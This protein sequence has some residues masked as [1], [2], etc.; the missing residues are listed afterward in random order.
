MHRLSTNLR[1]SYC[2]E[3][4]SCGPVTVSSSMSCSISLKNRPLHCHECCCMLCLRPSPTVLW[5]L[6]IRSQLSL[7]PSTAHKTYLLTPRGWPDPLTCFI[8]HRTTHQTAYPLTYHRRPGRRL[9]TR[10]V[11]ACHLPGLSPSDD[12]LEGGAQHLLGG[13]GAA[14]RAGQGPSAASGWVPGRRRRPGRRHRPRRRR[15]FR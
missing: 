11:R 12:L 14:L 10:A 4:F 5:Y 13:A 3:T 9:C 8:S 6:D 15:Y 2:N 7:Q 1:Y